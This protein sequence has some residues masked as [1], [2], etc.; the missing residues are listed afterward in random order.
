MALQRQINNGSQP[1]GLCSVLSDNETWGSY[2]Q[3][4]GWEVLGEGEDYI[5]VEN[6]KCFFL[7]LQLVNGTVKKL[8]VHLRL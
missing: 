8:W 2:N 1:R 5:R 4:L 6:M 3:G 7:C